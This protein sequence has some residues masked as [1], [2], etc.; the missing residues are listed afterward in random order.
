MIRITKEADYA[1]MLLARLAERP[2]GEVHAARE[3][4]SWS[5]LTLPM[6]SKILRTLAQGRILRSHRGV[7]GGYSLG[8]PAEETS[9]AE[10]IR[11]LD[12]PISIVQCGAE[13]G[14]CDREPVCPT[15]SNWALISRV[16][17]RALERV[18]ISEMVGR[19][20]TEELLT[21]SGEPATR[22]LLR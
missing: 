8:R 7:S 22:E 3:I 14:A 13:P 10:V 21:L 4:A 5:G 19:S 11:A 6:V 15:R 20:G 18:P 9:V 12:G 1:I 17:E 2:H 16:L